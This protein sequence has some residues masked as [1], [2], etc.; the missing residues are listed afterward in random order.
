MASPR[1]IVDAM[2]GSL[3]RWLRILGL[4]AAY[5][6]A[7]DDAELVEIALG[8]G[9]V[10]LT[11]DSRLIERRLL[12]DNGDSYLFVRDDGVEAQLRQVLGELGVKIGSD[13]LFGRCL[14][15]NVELAALT[16][17]EARPQVPPFVARTQR[18]YRRCPNCERIYWSAT[19][20]EAMAERLRGMGVIVG[21]G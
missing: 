20:V 11:R 14:R 10:L 6:P 2:L 21:E 17:E 8:E 18:R 7:L 19:H 5:D 16:A 1:F 4:D 3:A 15:C 9:R 13:R 12:R